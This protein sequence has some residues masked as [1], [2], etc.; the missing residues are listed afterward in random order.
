M[1]F[2]FNHKVGQAFAELTAATKVGFWSE[3]YSQ[4]A[5]IPVLYENLRA[6]KDHQNN[7]F[8]VK[9]CTLKVFEFAAHLL[10]VSRFSF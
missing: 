10:E 4:E 5:Q 9:G 8:L 7:R 1:E 3:S 6:D 2:L